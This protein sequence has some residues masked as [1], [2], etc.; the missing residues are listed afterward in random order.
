MTTDQIV[1]IGAG[2]AGVTA[3]NRLA[4]RGG[5]RVRVT[6]VNPREVFVER[7]RLHQQ[8]ATGHDPTV[9]LSGLLRPDVRLR[10][11]TAER[12]GDGSVRLPGGDEIAFDHC[13]LAVGAVPQA[14]DTPEG[15]AVGDLDSSRALR[16]RLRAL[17]PGS[18]VTVVGGGLTGVETVTEIAEAH[19]RLHVR[20]AA[21]QLAED[22]PDR[23]RRRVARTLDRLGVEVVGETPQDSDCL[24]WATG[25]RAPSLAADSGL[26]VDDLGRLLTDETL[27]S[28]ANPRVVATGDAAAPPSRLAGRLRP[29]CQ[30]AFP[31]GVAAADTVLRRIDGRDPQPT[32]A[33]FAAQCVSLG[34]RDGLL[35]PVRRDDAPRGPALTGR[36]GALAKEAVCRSTLTRLRLGARG[37]DRG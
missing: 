37:G 12:I 34:R 10:V 2:Y 7:I 11:T 13:V 19:P 4:R 33:P 35:Q 32:Q 9:P 20:L 23:A 1:V 5:D 6:L 17:D 29:S 14:L 31:L 21:R 3:A 27:T 36:A 26:P 24:V 28:L 22:L 15:Y 30:A 18:T 8:A 25:D 16:D